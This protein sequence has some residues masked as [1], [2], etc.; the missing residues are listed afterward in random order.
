MKLKLILSFLFAIFIGFFSFAESNP[1]KITF[2]FTPGGKPENLKK[3]ALQL[4][5]EV[6]KQFNIPVEIYISKD[7]AGLVEAMRLKKVDFAFFSSMTFVFA[8]KTAGA[9]VL[10]KKVWTDPFYFSSIVTLEDSNIKKI[11]DLKGKRIAFVDKNSASGFLYPQVMLKKMKIK[12]SD[13]KEVLFS[14][15]HAAS[16]EWLENLKVDAIAVFSDDSAGRSGAWT[17]FSKKKNAKFNM[18]WVSEPIPTD[19]FCVRKDFYELY[20]KFSHSLMFSLID[21]FTDSKPKQIYDEVL[22]SKDLV[23]ATSKQYDPVREMVKEL[24]PVLQ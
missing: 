2:G 11:E 3:Q 24:N 23:P 21:I 9:K 20:P 8:E 6:Q 12:D 4:A 1:Q 16:V 13:F 7:Y 5:K 14:Q 18:L 22:G 19:P 10:L 17:K 15:N